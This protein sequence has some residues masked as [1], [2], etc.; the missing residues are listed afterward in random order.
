MNYNDDMIKMIKEVEALKIDVER[1][2]SDEYINGIKADG[3]ED[4]IKSFSN[5]GLYDDAVQ[6]H[7]DL[8][9]FIEDLR[10]K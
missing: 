9:L 5:A 3:I 7:Y 2:T 8:T 6:Y 4:A 1:L 10:S